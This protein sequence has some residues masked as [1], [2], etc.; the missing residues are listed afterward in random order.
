MHEAS[1]TRTSGTKLTRRTRAELHRGRSDGIA[2]GRA[3]EGNDKAEGAAPKRP[4][5]FGPGP[6]S[7]LS[8]GSIGPRM[9]LAVRGAPTWSFVGGLGGILAEGRGSGPTPKDRPVPAQREARRRAPRAAHALKIAGVR[10]LAIIGLPDAA[11]DKDGWNQNGDDLAEPARGAI[12]LPEAALHPSRLAA[13]DLVHRHRRVA[14][15]AWSPLGQIDDSDH[16]GGRRGDDS[17]SPRGA[18]RKFCSSNPSARAHQ[19]A[20]RA[21]S[22]AV[23]S[24]R[25]LR[26]CWVSRVPDQG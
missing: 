7:R 18:S 19:R 15:V 22:I 3:H 20:D 8:D 21:E 1:A 17:A 6:A 16:A 9:F 14:L 10:S 5:P 2:I 13:F 12:V 4:I 26:F 23:E 11:F 24:L 25:L